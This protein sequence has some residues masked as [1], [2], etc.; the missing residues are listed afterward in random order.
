MDDV[1]VA[2]RQQVPQG[3]HPP[4]IGVVSGIEGVHGRSTSRNRRDQGVLVPEHV[5]HLAMEPGP[6]LCGHHVHRAGVRHPRSRGT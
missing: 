6:V 3:H 4:Q 5:G 2:P 1:E